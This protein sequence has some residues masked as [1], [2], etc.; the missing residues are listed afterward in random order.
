MSHA[1]TEST[2]W[3]MSSGESFAELGCPDHA[4]LAISKAEVYRT[5][6]PVPPSEDERQEQLARLME[7]M[8]AHLDTMVTLE[9]RSHQLSLSLLDALR[10]I[11][12]QTE[13]NGNH[14]QE[15]ADI[16]AE[17]AVKKN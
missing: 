13:T 15:L 9:R 4:A 11:H 6:T 1:D 2:V 14:L 3:S 10:L 8:E 7:R 12:H 5:R 17:L 16:G